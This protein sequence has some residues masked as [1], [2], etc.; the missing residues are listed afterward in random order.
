MRTGRCTGRYSGSPNQ[1]A[2]GRAWQSCLEPAGHW[3]RP[4]SP[5]S[6]ILYGI[7]RKRGRVKPYSYPEDSKWDWIFLW[8]NWVIN[9]LSGQLPT[10]KGK[11]KLWVCTASLLGSLLAFPETSLVPTLSLGKGVDK[12]RC[13][14]C[15]CWQTL[16]EAKW[17][18]AADP[19][20]M[21]LHTVVAVVI[22]IVGPGLW[23]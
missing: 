3:L 13:W 10:W 9:F 7:K 11:S 22:H 1:V 6:Q 23:K 14:Y 17:L 19:L 4:E 5:L 12:G 20:H 8:G 16:R 18:P 15:C 21:G 2:E